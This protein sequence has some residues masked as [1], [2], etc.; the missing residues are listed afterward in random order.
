MIR[1]SLDRELVEAD[2]LQVTI[3]ARAEL[4]RLPGFSYAE[5]K[6]RQ[7]PVIGMPLADLQQLLQF[8]FVEPEPAASVA[9]IDLEIMPSQ[10]HQTAIALGTDRGHQCFSHI[11]TAPDLR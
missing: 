11:A 4:V 6:F 10:D 3:A 5:T 2:L 9:D 8:A 1:A 7:E